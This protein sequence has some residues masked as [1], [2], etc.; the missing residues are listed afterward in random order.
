[1][2][3]ELK[4]GDYVKLKGKQPMN[5]SGYIAF[6]N[7]VYQIKSIRPGWSWFDGNYMPDLLYLDVPPVPPTTTHNTTIPYFNSKYFINII[8]ERKEKLEKLKMPL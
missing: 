1:M 2:N 8:K 6:P 5:L 3:E 4:I 7:N